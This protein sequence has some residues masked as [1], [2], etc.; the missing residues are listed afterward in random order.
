MMS[1]G[2]EVEGLARLHIARE[3][4]EGGHA[5][6]GA[7][8]RLLPTVVRG[9]TCPRWDSSGQRLFPALM[10][11][12]AHEKTEQKPNSGG[13]PDH[14]HDVVDDWLPTANVN[15]HVVAIELQR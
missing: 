10:L 1:P 8:R 15:S 12:G 4:G 6:A 14:A 11:V 2:R 13:K 5:P 3:V 7:S 9:G